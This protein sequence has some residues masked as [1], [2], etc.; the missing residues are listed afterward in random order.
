LEAK[1]V[2]GKRLPHNKRCR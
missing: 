2:K 1:K